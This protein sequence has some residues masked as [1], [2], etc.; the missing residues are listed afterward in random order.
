MGL[1]FAGGLTSSA[2][3]EPSNRLLDTNGLSTVG[4]LFGNL[5]YMRENIKEDRDLSRHDGL[6]GNDRQQEGKKGR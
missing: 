3:S 5:Q 4:A 6:D 2:L 1:Y